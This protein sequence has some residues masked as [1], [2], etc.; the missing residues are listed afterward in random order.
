MRYSQSEKM[1][2]IRIVENSKLGAKRTLAELGINRSTFYNWY[3]RYSE[4]G[5]YALASRPPHRR[6]FWNAIPPDVKQKVIETALEHLDKS[7]PAACL[8]SH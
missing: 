6:R 4:G 2:I 7:P 1:E 5:Y 3:K 8:V